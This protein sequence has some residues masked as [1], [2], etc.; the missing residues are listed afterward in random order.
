MDSPFRKR[1]HRWLLALWDEK[2][3]DIAALRGDSRRG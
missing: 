1:V 3:A 2:D